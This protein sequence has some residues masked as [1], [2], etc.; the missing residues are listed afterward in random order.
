MGPPTRRRTEPQATPRGT[1]TSTPT[2]T[3]SS[4]GGSGRG[5]RSGQAPVTPDVQAAIDAAM[6]LTGALAED[7]DASSED[8]QEVRRY[9]TRTH[10][11][12]SRYGQDAVG[13]TA[14]AATVKEAARVKTPVMVRDLPPP[15]E[16]VNEALSRDDAALWRAALDAERQSVIDHNVWIKHKASPGASRLGTHVVFSYKLDQMGVL[17]RP[18]CPFVGE[19]NRQKPGR[20]YDESWAAMPAAATT[21]AVMATAAARGWHVHHL[22]IKTVYIYAPMDKDV[23]ISIPE[24]FDDAGEEALLKY[25]M[26][27]TKQAG[28][29]RG[30]LLHKTMVDEG[31]VQSQADK[32]LYLFCVRG[33]TVVVEVHVE[34]I[35]LCGPDLDAVLK[36]KE[37][38]LPERHTRH[39]YCL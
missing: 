18:M 12:P 27:G 34:D 21:R 10:D 3:R 36:V 38:A 29:L 16:T 8:E 15:P 35:L 33:E 19:G 30:K 28:N 23:Y 32:C 37:G 5:G 14:S 39:G 11:V 26:Y 22:D 1:P 7:G 9:P 17:E 6:Q 24:G 4:S 31:G 13:A 2:L 25:A 20:D